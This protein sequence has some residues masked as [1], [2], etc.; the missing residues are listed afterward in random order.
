MAERIL[1]ILPRTEG[2]KILVV[3][4]AENR[5]CWILA[6]YIIL[7][8]RLIRCL[9][10]ILIEESEKMG[11]E[12]ISSMGTGNIFDPPVL[13]WRISPQTSVLSLAKGCRK[14]LKVR[15]IAA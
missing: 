9:Q 5:I 2:V 7:W 10:A 3:Y 8:M 12:V 1:R 6:S 15:G 14:E 11:T 13:R 4:G